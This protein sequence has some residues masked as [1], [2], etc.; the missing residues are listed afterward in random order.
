[1][2][3]GLSYQLAGGRD[4]EC[5]L[6]LVLDTQDETPAPGWTLHLDLPRAVA[7]GEGTVLEQQVGSHLVLSP[8]R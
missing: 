3:W 4:G 7:A 5:L 8:G 1:M 6:T 2:S